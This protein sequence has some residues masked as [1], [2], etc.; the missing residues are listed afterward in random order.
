MTRDSLARSNRDRS[1]KTG[2]LF[3]S[4]SSRAMLTASV[5]AIVATIAGCR[6]PQD[7][8]PTQSDADRSAAVILREGDTVKITFPG[9]P[10]LNESQQIR[11]DGKLALSL[12]GEVTAAGL[13]PSDLEKEI[14]KLYAPQLVTKEVMVTVVSS[15]FPVFVS[16]SVVRPGK[17]LSDHPITALEAIMEAGGFDYTKAD[18]GHVRVVRTEKD[19]TKTYTLNLKN[20]LEA[21][22]STPFYLKPS[23]IVYVP[24][25]F[26]WF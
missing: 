2:S 21:S 5:I 16:G 24:E 4:R 14:L 25:R 10:N 8:L 3:T 23:D 15:S 13:T 26:N 1:P 17:I 12:V 6:T 7:K 18:I 11:R 20:A 19:G 9:A 22:H